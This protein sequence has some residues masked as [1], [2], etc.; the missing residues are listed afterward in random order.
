M[1]GPALAE[2]TVCDPRTLAAGEVR[3][4][5]IPCGDELV[6]GGEGR[7]GDWL[8]ENAHARYVVR[9]TYA[10]LTHLGEAGGTL[11][12]AAPPGG[13][14]VLVEY[15]PDGDRSA[16]I[17][18]NDADEARLVLPGVTYRLG[19]DDDVLHIDA[20]GTGV[21]QGRPTVTRTGATLW[22]D[23]TAGTGAFVGLDGLVVSEGSAVRVQGVTRAA[24]S[25]EGLWP[26]GDDLDEAVD[27]DS[28]LAVQGGV[29]RV[30]LPIVDGRAAGRAPAGSTLQAERAG[31]TYDGTRLLAC[32]WLQL[33]VADDAGND[34]VAAIYDGHT[35][36]T[37]P[38]GGG[39]VPLGPEPATL[40]VWAG[41]THSAVTLP[42]AGV[43]TEA[44]VT[45]HH[46]WLAD[47]HVLAAPAMV[48][49][50]DAASTITSEA[51]ATTL[52]AEGVGF[53]VLLV[54]D[55][56]PTV[57]IDAHDAIL[58][59]AA[60]RASGEVWS[61]P[62]NPNARKPAHGAVAWQG[63]S[64]LDLL[65]A[66]EGG[67]SNARL[68]VVNAAWVARARAE[69]EPYDWDPRPDAFWIDTPADIPAWLAL[70]DAWVDPAPL[71]PRT[72]I[73]IDADANVPAYEA[74]IV[75]ARTTAGTGPRLDVVSR[76]RER[77]AWGIDV[78]LD[79]S[80]WMRMRTVEVVTSAGSVRHDVAGAGTWKWS[81]PAETTW[82]VVVAYG[83][84][85]TPWSTEPAWAVS[86][87][88]WIERRWTDRP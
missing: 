22:G 10:A 61:W 1:N 4:R 9:G 88:L 2:P 39:R 52:A 65:A 33:R 55:E 15:V 19:A 42:W 5:Q 72:W 46:E 18:E 49:A 77:G 20:V 27:A 84:R 83:E 45:L 66:T 50:P 71:G 60:S 62:W 51:A 56:V 41:P 58:A 38:P 54:D 87:P 67:A 59:V 78:T 63:L 7:T 29:E 30:R 23:P 76:G 13:L 44:A 82:V 64:A 68:T 36:W 32:A 81:V 73:G 86:A 35:T 3:A 28:V 48:V 70:L 21:L 69:A 53:A 6:G 85:A 57:T 11:I 14:D 74:G 26:D 47:D 75:D 34:V 25:R 17:A 80:R 31:C 8:I 79:A 40:W 37:V 16:I 43:D 24:L 12:D